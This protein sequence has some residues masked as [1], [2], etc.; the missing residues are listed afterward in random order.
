MTNGWRLSLLPDSLLLNY[1]AWNASG[2]NF[3][4]Y[5]SSGLFVNHLL[6]DHENQSLLINSSSPSP[7]S[8]IGVSFN[9]FRIKTLS[10][11]VGQ[12]SLLLDGELIGQTDLRDI[13]SNPSFTSNS[14]R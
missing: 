6:I 7:Q 8:P 5:D 14:R 10:S 2:D 1:D 11:F 13:L 3:I 9:H 4:Q 12:D